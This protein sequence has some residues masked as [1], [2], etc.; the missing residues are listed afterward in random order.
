MTGITQFLSGKK[1]NL[2]AGWMFAGAVA[3][4][5]SG[6]MVNT[7]TGEIV[8]QNGEGGLA[9]I[10]TALS[11]ALATLRA[12][13]TKIQAALAK[14]TIPV[15]AFGGLA[16][17]MVGCATLGQTDPLTGETFAAGIQGEVINLAPLFGPMLSTIIPIVTGSA[18]NIA[19]ILGNMMNSNDPTIIPTSPLR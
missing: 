12:S 6:A 18:L 3:L 2:S 9:A 19:T 15:I 1:A 11:V 10:L 14:V 17:Y 8:L 5:M 13:N 4:L 16:L 7:E